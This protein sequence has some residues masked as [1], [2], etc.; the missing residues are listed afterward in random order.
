MGL[1]SVFKNGAAAVIKAVGDIAEDAWYY[2]T[3]STTYDVSAG[4][5]STVDSAYFTSGI[6]SKYKAH[7]IDN[8]NVLPH[9]LKFSVPQNTFSLT[10]N[11]QD[12]IKRL[13]N[14][15]STRYDVIDITQDSAG[16]MWHIQLR[17]P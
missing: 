17:K 16:A 4:V 12:F 7:E 2:Q 5:V 3:G 15:A 14:Y 11:Q 10:P 9:D 8:R 1:E 13:E 6:F